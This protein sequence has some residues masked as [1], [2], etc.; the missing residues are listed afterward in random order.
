[1]SFSG[2]N[3]FGKSWVYL[4]FEYFSKNTNLTLT[5]TKTKELLQ[6]FLVVVHSQSL[7]IKRLKLDISKEF[8]LKIWCR[9]LIRSIFCDF[10]L[11]NTFTQ[12]IHLHPKAYQ[13]F[14][15][16]VCESDFEHLMRLI[17][18]DNSLQTNKFYSRLKRLGFCINLPR[19]KKRVF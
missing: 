6:I 15:S 16:D 17:S 3:I 1:M 2:K 4:F 19:K 5:R 12:T 8:N 18:S 10:L 9:Y 7:K 13:W 11:H 14:V